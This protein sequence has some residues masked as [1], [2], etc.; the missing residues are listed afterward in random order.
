[1]DRAVR[2]TVPLGA[3]GQAWKPALDEVWAVLRRSPHMTPGHNLFLYHHPEVRG[4]PM[5]VDFGV[6]VPHPSMRQGNLRCIE[7]PAGE[8]ATTLHLG[9][10]D[11]LPAAHEAIHAWC[12]SNNR[13]IGGASWEIYGDPTPDPALT[14]TAVRYLLA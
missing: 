6:Q 11:Q 4:A 8:V 12:A 9:P 13:H 14:Q 10:Y 7:V 3:V 5:D 2:V 1:M